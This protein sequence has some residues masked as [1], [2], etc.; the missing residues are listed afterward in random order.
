MSQNCTIPGFS[1][2]AGHAYSEKHKA[3][4]SCLS[5]SMSF[6]PVSN[7]FILMLMWLSL[8][9]SGQV[10]IRWFTMKNGAFVSLPQQTMHRFRQHN[11]QLESMLHVFMYCTCK[12]KTITAVFLVH[13]CVYITYTL[14]ITI[15]SVLTVRYVQS[16]NRPLN[17]F[18]INFLFYTETT[19]VVEALVQQ[20]KQ[21]EFT[22]I[23]NTFCIY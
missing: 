2:Y 16:N 11:L 17:V 1:Y 6:F 18:Y 5:V 12:V 13:L 19:T 3:T 23:Q 4:V 7:V 22:V 20:T 9:S 21:S 15:T 10:C 8:I 14:N